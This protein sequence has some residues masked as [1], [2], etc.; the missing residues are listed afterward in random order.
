MS[1]GLLAPDG[2]SYQALI[3]PNATRIND[4][5][6]SKCKEYAEAGL[7]IIFMEASP[8]SLPRVPSQ[9]ETV[10]ALR[11]RCKESDRFRSA[12]LQ[13]GGDIKPWKNFEDC[14]FAITL[15]YITCCGKAHDSVDVEATW[16]CNRELYQKAL[17]VRCA[18][19][20][21]F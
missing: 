21:K 20:M 16:K 5:V 8:Y 17:K 14:R 15:D 12:D 13:T 9:N 7:P 18:L 11:A 19:A 1:Q 10:T 2:P 3:I 4:K 6:L